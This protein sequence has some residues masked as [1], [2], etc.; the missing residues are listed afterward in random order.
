MDEPTSEHADQAGSPDAGGSTPADIDPLVQGD[1]TAE[2]SD[3]TT[4]AGAESAAAESDT[5]SQDDLNSLLDASKASSSNEDVDVEEAAWADAAEPQ[6]KAQQDTQADGSRRPAATTSGGKATPGA[7]GQG[8]ARVTPA[9]A[10]PT[11]EE[12]PLPDLGGAE[13][14]AVDSRRVTMLNDVNLRVKL[15]LG[16]TQMLVEDVLKLNEGSVVELDKLA[17]DPIDVLINDRL[18]ARGEVLVLN[19]VFCVR[20]SE[21]LAHDPHR[22]TE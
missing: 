4:P 7:Q 14:V 1:D 18:I 12:F 17:G 9:D 21:V 15:Q 3:G 22:V 20:V 13:P 19:D 10:S 6:A 2:V 5:L 11:V 16:R 8:S